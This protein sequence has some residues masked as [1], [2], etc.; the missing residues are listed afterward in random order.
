MLSFM[1]IFNFQMKINLN[2]S[3]VMDLIFIIFLIQS[4]RHYNNLHMLIHAIYLSKN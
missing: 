1:I 3:F 2:I 4:F